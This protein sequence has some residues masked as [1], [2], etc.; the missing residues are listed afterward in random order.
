MQ[1][2]TT[3]GKHPTPDELLDYH[4]ADISP[5]Q[6]SRIQ[7]HL[8]LCP[9]CIRTVLDLDSFPDIPPDVWKERLSSQEIE[10]EWLRFQGMATPARSIWRSSFEL[11]KAL[12]WGIAASLLIVTAGLSVQMVRFHRE[13]TQPRSGLELVDLSPLEDGKAEWREGEGE[14]VRPAP[15]VDRLVLILSLA[16]P[17]SFPE[18]A[19]EIAAADG[20]VVWHGTKLRRAQEGT[21]ALELPRHFLTAG[22]YRI[23][24][25]GF[26]PEGRSPVAE[27]ELHL[28]D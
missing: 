25:F 16:A 12:P 10:A 27:Y 20:R 9:D 8:V 15:W 3:P 6:R 4:T 14:G 7:D 1:T 23:R 18:Y 2:H 22:S 19:V 13:A 17:R 5:E 21:L 11:A 24:L 26:P 28:V